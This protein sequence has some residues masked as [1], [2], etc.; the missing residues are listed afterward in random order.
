MY[1]PMSIEN[2]H[3]TTTSKTYIHSRRFIATPSHP[4]LLKKRSYL[5]CRK[6]SCIDPNRYI[7]TRNT[8][9]HLLNRRRFRLPTCLLLLRCRTKKMCVISILGKV[10]FR[11][12]CSNK[13]QAYLQP[14]PIGRV[15]RP[16]IDHTCQRLYAIQRGRVEAVPSITRIT[17]HTRENMTWKLRTGTKF[18]VQRGGKCY[19]PYSMHGER[20]CGIG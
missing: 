8:W 4:T 15:S 18:F 3:D 2:H 14:P 11:L 16:T 1:L 12:Q 19:I 6:H 10:S 20:R 9:W 5:P 13:Q 7:L 17:Q